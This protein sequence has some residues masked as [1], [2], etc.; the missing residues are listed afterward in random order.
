MLYYLTG[1]GLIVHALFWGFGL[2][3]LA[4]PRIWRRW[5]WVFAPGFGFALQSAV[6][7]A[8]THTLLAGTDAYAWW[9]E[10]IPALLLIAAVVRDRRGILW[11]WP[12]LWILT[13]FAG[14]L[15]L[16][17]MTK[18]GAGLTTSSLGNCDQADYAAGARVFQEFSRDD[19]TGFLGLP[20][21]TKV[22]SADYFFDFWVRLNH[23]TPSALIAHNASI[24]G[25]ESFRLVSVTA[26][27]VML[28]NIP[29]VLFM[30]RLTVGLRGIWLI[31]FGALYALSP[32]NAYAIYHGQLGQL[33]ATQGIAVLTVAVFGASRVAHSGRSVWPFFAL[34][35]AAFW[36]LAGSYN[37]ILPVCLAPA[38][39]WLAIQ[40]WRRRNWRAAGRLLAMVA[41]A[42]GSCVVLFWGRF[43]GLIERFSLFHQYNFGWAVPLFSPEGLLGIF[44]DSDLHP[45]PM[46]VRVILSALVLGLSVAGLT[47]L[48]RREKTHALAALA[49]VLPVVFGWSILAWEARVR[50]N[51]SY[52]AYKIISVFFPG[53]L[54]GAVCWL[55]AVRRRS[56]CVRIGAAGILLLIL[57]A[58]LSLDG[59][60]RRRMANPPLRATRN[61]AEL[62]VLEKDPTITSLNNLVEDYWRRLW[63]NVFL[64]R[65]PQY[66]AIHTYEGR[67]NTELKGEWNLSDS[68]LRTEPLRDEDYRPFS[69]VFYL[70]RAAAP[71]LMKAS[72][73]EGWY[74]EERSGPRRW[75][76]SSGEGR[77]LLSNPSGVPARV[78]LRL[79]VQS[80]LP[81]PMAVHFGAETLATQSLDASSQVVEFESILLPPGPTVLTLTSA[82]LSPGGTDS[83]LLA[84]A[85][86][87][88]EM[89]TLALEK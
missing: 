81:Q 38:G 55:A 87:G 63:A 72:F 23:F 62:S 3:L 49:L 70:V 44:G 52:D 7:W 22:R 48:W 47:A 71:G 43:D 5:A 33:Y 24:F 13:I 29:I 37:F 21:V 58:N 85:L 84:F 59:H 40:V 78:R 79:S 54:A 19:R 76:W 83:R 1:A 15:I 17:P 39:T 89:R 18:P 46:V 32:L 86:Y 51:A 73:T 2:A 45:W 50:A 75:R 88:L 27:A 60:F 66:F 11:K 14:W 4:L 53:L 30:G 6:V 67:L 74:N 10:S 26:V 61:I 42:F 8:G 28:L 80:L 31:G 35:F 82:A 12:G 9:S 20:E 36:L 64:L 77:I 41:A 68:L 34:I 25:V 65:K 56:W 69:V 57:A 16:V